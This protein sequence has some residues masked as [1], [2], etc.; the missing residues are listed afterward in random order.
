MRRN[1]YWSFD[2]PWLVR[3]TSIR[4]DVFGS[5]TFPIILLSLLAYSFAQFFTRMERRNGNVVTLASRQARTGTPNLSIMLV[6]CPSFGNTS[7]VRAG[8]ECWSMP[9]FSPASDR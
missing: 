8:R 2:V 3:T 6:W 1:K 5:E 4:S 9:A 7:L